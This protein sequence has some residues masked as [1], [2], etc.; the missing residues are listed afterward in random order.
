MLVCVCVSDS[1]LHEAAL[2]SD[3]LYIDH[4]LNGQRDKSG[5]RSRNVLPP[6]SSLPRCVSVCMHTHTR[7]HSTARGMCVVERLKA[8]IHF[9]VFNFSEDDE[10]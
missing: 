4:F 7:M 9:C 6:F 8:P 10:C 2:P 1:A 5:Q 3:I